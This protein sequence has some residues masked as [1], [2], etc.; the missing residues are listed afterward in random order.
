MLS[1]V[2]LVSCIS[3]NNYKDRTSIAREHLLRKL[4]SQ[5]TGGKDLKIESFKK[6]DDLTFKASFTFISLHENPEILN[7]EYK[8]SNEM[9]LTKTF[10]FNSTLDS[11][12]KDTLLKVENRN[13][14]DWKS[15]N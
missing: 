5:Y 8:Y 4:V 7:P 15:F 9:R 14:S 13:V 2:L 10:F 1:I 12:L 3:N 11:I 6:V